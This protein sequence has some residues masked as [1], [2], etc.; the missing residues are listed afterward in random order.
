MSYS[1]YKNN[2]VEW[3]G[4]IPSHWQPKRLKFVTSRIVDGTHFTPDYIEQGVPFLR[5]TDITKGQN[6]DFEK[7][8]R[9][10]EDEHLELNLR[11]NPKKGDLLLSKNGTIGIPRVV[12]W[13]EPFSIFVSL[14]LIKPK[15]E[16]D[17]NFLKHIF[18]SKGI[19]EQINAGGKTNTITNLHLDKIREFYLSLPP[20]EEQKQIAKFLDKEVS[21][22][23]LLIHKKKQFI[24]CL[25]EKKLA[26]ISNAVTKGLNPDVKMKKN[27]VEWM[28]NV[29]E[30]W[31]VWKISHGF[32]V[33]GSGT[34]P[35][36]ED[37]EYYE[38]DINWVTTSELRE[39]DIESSKK[40]ITE[41]ALQE[42][43][44]LKL[45]PPGTLLI[46][47]YGATIGRLGILTC[48]ASVNQACCALSE[49]IAFDIKFV[50]YW[51]IMAKPVLLSLS[52]GGGQPNLSQEII[53]NTRIPVPDIV[54]QTEIVK[55][56]DDE[57][58]KIEEVIKTGESALDKLN[59]YRTALISSTVTGKIKVID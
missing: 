47:M 56:I 14:C 22:I 37:I 29:P 12:D 33:I 9:I 19:E 5:V 53:K 38:G 16:I 50:F 52:A 51:F 44:A 6:I 49:P 11:C 42:L 23:D 20:I 58:K 55:Y 26:I 35:N 4:E 46:A 21:R 31:E 45:Y 48:N 13:D 28:E 17:V 15:E 7:V 32:K 3:L 59:E 18:L 27:E 36:T 34:T 10:S 30:H 25:K 8:K 39:N 40:K 1:E 43:S 24:D 54:E 41:K 57:I 2:G